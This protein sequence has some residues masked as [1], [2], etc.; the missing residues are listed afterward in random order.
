MKKSIIFLLIIFFNHAVSIACDKCGNYNNS[1][2]KIKSASI[3]HND[4]L[5]ITVWS[6]KVEG[7]AGKT[8]PKPVGQLNGAP[9]LGYV[10]PTTLKAAD[11]GF[12]QAEG[13][14]ALA[15]TSHPDF[16]DTPLWD[17]NLDGNYLNDG[18]IWHAHWVLLVEDKRVGGG[19]SVREFKK[20]DPNVVLPPTNPGMAMYMDS[21]G[22]NI[23]TKGNLIKVIVPD[24]RINNKT[25]FKFD[26]VSCY[27]EVSTG[28]GGSHDGEGTKPMLGV[29]K[30]YDVASGNL[31]LPYSVK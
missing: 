19:L 16:E 31:S 21:P 13:I 15:L 2:F 4:D 18:L 27:M 14:V 9:V 29:Y 24:F 28:A 8:M 23:V 26:A 7:T 25:N 20:G 6:I 12:G 11:I 10:F 1:D 5:G 22:F 30:V 3:T 17:E